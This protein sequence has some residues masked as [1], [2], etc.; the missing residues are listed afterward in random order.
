MT[1]KKTWARYS[2]SNSFKQRIA[3]LYGNG[4]E[5]LESQTARYEKL[6]DRH[7]ARF[8]VLDDEMIFFSAPGRTEIGGNH[9]DHNAG[10]VL[11]AAVNLDT[12]AAVTATD[13]TVIVVDSEGYPPITV[14][15]SDLSVQQKQYGTSLA[16]I[17]GTAAIMKEYGY[18]IGGFKATVTSSV[19]RASGLSSSAAFEVL[20]AAILDGL[21]NG[22]TLDPKTRAQI[23]QKVENVY[24]GK[25]SGLMDQM[26][27]SVGGLVTID[28]KDSDPIIE[29][30]QYD[31][32]KKGFHLVVV[33]TGGS[34]S[35][36]TADYA[37]IRTEMESVAAQFGKQVLRQVDPA[38]VENAIPTLRKKVG[39]RAILRSLH[40]YDDNAR[41]LEQVAALKSDD[42]DSFLDAINRSGESSWKLLQ[43]VWAKPTEQE[44][45]L[46]LELSHRVL[47]GKGAWRVHGGGFAGTIQAFV[48]HDLLDIYTERLEACY[49]KGS[50]T[51][52]SIR[53]EGAVKMRMN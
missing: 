24:F 10:R 8:G 33:D 28:F 3:T 2:A 38:E 7:Q 43:N 6:I 14:N 41:V 44:I 22:F 40:Y 9:T 21:Y 46:A 5:V 51:I 12:V 17:R 39:D 48:P 13:D 32:D 1:T 18:K 16:L 20:I 25:P 49:G 42:L 35:D 29:G 36:L 37:A 15:L 45:T 4:E 19:L 52:L 47:Q 11:A 34:H 26:A 27:S 31:F 53:P 30:L 23:A 50:C